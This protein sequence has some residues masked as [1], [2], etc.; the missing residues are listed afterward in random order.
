MTESEHEVAFDG[1]HCPQCGWEGTEHQVHGHIAGK[2]LK[3][4]KP[5]RHGTV[6]GYRAEVNRGVPTCTACKVAWR[7]YYSAA[8]KAARRI[9]RGGRT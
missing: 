6:R 9:L 5:I 3:K 8:S 7:R 4:L 2:H 1:W